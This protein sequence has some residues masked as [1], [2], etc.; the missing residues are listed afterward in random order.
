MNTND[1]NRDSRKPLNATHGKDSIEI[2][3]KEAERL[4]EMGKFAPM[5]GDLGDESKDKGDLPVQERKNDN[6]YDPAL[7]TG[8][9][10]NPERPS[11][12]D[13]MHVVDAGSSGITAKKGDS[14]VDED[15]NKKVAEEKKDANK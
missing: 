9:S 7:A 12:S 6:G 4:N 10:P 1:K 11:G 5:D 2:E 15:G 3:K 14:Y 8:G 13:G